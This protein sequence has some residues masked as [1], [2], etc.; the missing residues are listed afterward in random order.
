MEESM[1]MRGMI[2][3]QSQRHS[4]DQPEDG[5]PNFHGRLFFAS[6]KTRGVRGERRRIPRAK[7]NAGTGGAV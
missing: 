3:G 1:A 6:V 4:S 7:P 2:H 5:G